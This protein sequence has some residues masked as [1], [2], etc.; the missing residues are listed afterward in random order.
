MTTNSIDRRTALRGAAVVAAGATLAACGSSSTTT[1]AASSSPASVPS[2]DPTTT[3]DEIG[4]ATPAS[5]MA[6]AS[7]AAAAGNGVG[8]AAG[9]P[10]GGG[11]IFETAKLVVTQPT[12]GTYKAFTAVCTHQ[13]CIV[14]TISNGSIICPCHGSTYSLKDGSVINGPATKPL[15]E[16]KITV[17]GG[18]IKLG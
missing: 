5:A 4:G 17:T 3:F 10:V 18:T 12:A 7:N 16:E 15:A 14:S 8:S 1:S 2:V 9:I 6:T 13:G 11:A